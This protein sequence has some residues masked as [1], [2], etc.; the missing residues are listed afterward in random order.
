[1]VVTKVQIMAISSRAQSEIQAEGNSYYKGIAAGTQV[2]LF[3]NSHTLH[4]IERNCCVDFANTFVLS[5]KIIFNG[6]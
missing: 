4:Q 2:L 5:Y 6:I 3:I 1:M